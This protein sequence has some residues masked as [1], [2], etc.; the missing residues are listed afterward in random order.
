MDLGTLGVPFMQN[1]PSVTY[2][3]LYPFNQDPVHNINKALNICSN[4]LS[5]KIKQQDL[6]PTVL[7]PLV[8]YTS[9]TVYVCSHM[10]DSDKT[11]ASGD[12][13]YLESDLNNKNIIVI[14][15]VTEQQRK[16]LAAI[17]KNV[18]KISFTSLCFTCF[19]KTSKMK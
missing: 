6:N 19:T 1:I 17:K 14:D 13:F 15:T 7:N 12:L 9:T 5:G 3:S 2:K 16:Q 11:Q 18:L 4:L 8:A 10:Q